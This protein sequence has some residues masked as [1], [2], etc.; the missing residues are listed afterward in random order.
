MTEQAVYASWAPAASIS[1]PVPIGTVGA[2]T[3]GAKSLTLP[4]N[5]PI[6][7]LLFLGAAE[8]ATTLGTVTPSDSNT[9]TFTSY[10]DTL[11]STIDAQGDW[12]AAGAALTSITETF[13]SATTVNGL[14]FAG[15]YF[16][17]Q[18]T[19]SPEDS[20]VRKTAS[21]LS[22]SVTITASAA[23]AVANEMM[24]ALIVWIGTDSAYRR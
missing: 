18:A 17:G 7:S 10:S 19:S 23:A 12:A 5:T 15:L 1:Q 13:G 20:G 22:G 21:G 8:S 11:I 2:T 3:T 9:D 6:N 24:L 16:S 4:W 14:G